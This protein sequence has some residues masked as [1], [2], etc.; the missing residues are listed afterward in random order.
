MA[1]RPGIDDESVIFYSK[2]ERDP[3]SPQLRPFIPDLKPGRNLEILAPYHF[4]EPDEESIVSEN[5]R[6]YSDQ[7]SKN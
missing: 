6:F 5:S 7:S 3:S 2:E 4:L 1:L